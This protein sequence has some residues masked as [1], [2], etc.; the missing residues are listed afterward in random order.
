MVIC[1]NFNATFNNISVILW[2]SVLFVEET[3]R[4]GE[5]HRP[6]ASQLYHIL[7]YT[8]TWSRFELTTSALIAYVVVN[9]TTI[10]SRPRR[11]LVIFEITLWHSIYTHYIHGVLVHDFV[12][13]QTYCVNKH[14]YELHVICCRSFTKCSITFSIIEWFLCFKLYSCRKYWNY[15]LGNGDMTLNSDFDNFKL[16]LLPGLSL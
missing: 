13:G 8:S 12:S 9:S 2:R 5:N 6:V 14:H 4:P 16:F 11:S 10:W 7:L 3:A 15:V 1:V